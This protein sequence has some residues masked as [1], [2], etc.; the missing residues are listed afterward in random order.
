MAQD[1]VPDQHT[2]DQVHSSGPSESSII[3]TASRHGSGHSVTPIESSPMGPNNN[4]S[5]ADSGQ[6]VRNLN[7][8][9]ANISNQSVPL[10]FS[11]SDANRQSGGFLAGKSCLLIG[12]VG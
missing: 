10:S 3:S 4:S 5:T 11:F 9:Q 12:L 6:S 2:G 7:P 1:I 8:S